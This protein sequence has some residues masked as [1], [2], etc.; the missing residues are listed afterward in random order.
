[1]WTELMVEQVR[2]EMMSFFEQ[3]KTEASAE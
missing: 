1:M 3:L 2:Q